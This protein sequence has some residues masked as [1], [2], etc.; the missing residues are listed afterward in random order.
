VASDDALTVAAAAAQGFAVFQCQ[1]CADAIKAA[2]LAA[3]QRGQQIEIRGA[4]GRDFMVCLSYDGGQT[5][6]TQNGRHQGTRVGDVVF[7]NLHPNGL[8]FDD[9]LSDFDAIGG[10]VVTSVIDF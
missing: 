10:I 8:L 3:G 5:T 6:I 4:G 7:D 1:E 2:L 9:W